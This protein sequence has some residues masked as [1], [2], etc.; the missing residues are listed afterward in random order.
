M[1][2]YCTGGHTAIYKNYTCPQ[3]SY[4]QWNAKASSAYANGTSYNSPSTYAIAGPPLSF[5]NTVQKGND[6]VCNYKTPE[7]TSIVLSIPAPAGY[8]CKGDVQDE[9]T[10]ICTSGKELK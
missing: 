2:L 5:I 7:G 4:I 6:I 1:T 10:I 9:R 8:T 3:S